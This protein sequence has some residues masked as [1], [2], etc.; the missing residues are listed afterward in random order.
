MKLDSVIV[1]DKSEMSRQAF[2]RLFRRLTY[3]DADEI[4]V[5]SY[6]ING[7][8]VKLPRGVWDMLP[9]DLSV[10]DRRS[11]PPMPKVAYVKQLDAPGYAGQSGALKAMWDCEQGQVIAPPGRGKTEIGL[12]FAASCK[13]RTLVIVHTNALLKQW[14][15]RAKESVPGM[16]VGIIQGQSCQV[17]HLTVAMAQTLKRHVRDGGKFWRQFG[18]V[19]VDECFPAGT[20]VDGRPIEQI[21]V[22]DLVTTI[23]GHQ[24]RV[25]KVFKHE[26]VGLVRVTLA[27]QEIVCTPTHPFLTQTG[28]VAAI[29]LNSDSVVLSSKYESKGQMSR[30]PADRWSGFQIGQEQMGFVQAIRQGLLLKGMPSEMPFT[31]VF[32]SDVADESQVCIGTDE[33]SQSY[34]TARSAQSCQSTLERDW[35]QATDSRGQRAWPIESS[36]EVGEEVGVANGSDCQDR[37]SQCLSNSLQTRYCQC[38]FDDCNRSGRCISSSL[39]SQETRS[40]EGQVLEWVR[41]E[42]VE[43]L[44]PGS[45]GRFGGLCSDGY[46]YNLEVEDEHTY[47]ADGLAVHN[48]HHAAAETWEWLLNVCPAKFRFG[49][50][51]SEKRSDGRHP[52]VRFNVGPV[53]YKLK[54]ESGVPMVVRPVETRWRTTVPPQRWHEMM[55][56]LV[57]DDERNE[58][59][60]RVAVNEVKAGKY[61]LVLSRQISHL[62]NIGDHM[63]RLFDL[64]EGWMQYV[65]LVTGKQSRTMQNEHIKALRGGEIHCI[66]GT[67]I[68]EEGVDIPRL[69]SIILAYPGTE[70]TVLQKVGRGSRK[71]E[72][73]TETTIWDLVDDLV[74]SLARQFSDRRAWYKRN[75]IQLGKVM[76]YAEATGKPQRKGKVIRNV[77]DAATWLKSL[78]VAR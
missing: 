55:R 54:F 46:V 14:V 29:N 7:G 73:K 56:R 61:V 50:T 43:V 51:A 21:K 18:C 1:V 53:I 71:A 64:D 74:P 49:I 27:T 13:T 52:S 10:D 42:G 67:Q 76:R 31:R 57:N 40:K 17:E 26:P 32:V 36:R 45:D 28:W 3:V 5:V 66:L 2:E 58:I 37:V 78:R 11:C 24:R 25:S 68:F 9:S 69:N 30:V 34:E 33:N 20:H 77:E 35:S 72:G 47:F 12:A 4:E 41:V 65:K 75:S 6:E 23:S 22:G 59:I 19:I 16:K 63:A 70:I 39:G 44:E 62:Q 60:A 38:G 15:S 48:C 8:T